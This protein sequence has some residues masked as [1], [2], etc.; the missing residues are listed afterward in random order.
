MVKKSLYMPIK[1]SDAEDFIS[2]IGR[3]EVIIISIISIVSIIMSVVLAIMTSPIYGVFLSF[4]I[5]GASIFIIRRDISNENM[6]KK[7]MLI[8][9][10]I[11]AEKV[12]L[13]KYTTDI[14]EE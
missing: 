2:G 10:F 1:T 4:I 3:I 14:K 13:Y 5:I 12:Y 8:K 11:K 6:I 7:I 9:H